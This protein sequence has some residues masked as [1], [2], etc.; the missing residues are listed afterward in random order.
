MRI[1]LASRYSRRLEIVEYKEQ[2]HALGHVVTSRWLQGNHQ[3][4]NDDLYRGAAA[5]R[6]AREDV[7][8]LRSAE[9]LIAFTEEPRTTTSRGGRHV[10][11]GYALAV[12]MPI[13]VVG[14]REHVF[15]CLVDQVDTWLEALEWLA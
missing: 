14:P 12:G 7:D 5:E 10:E 13:L 9:R 4:E 2:L 1:Y 3:A 6:F 15:C 11:F 8:D